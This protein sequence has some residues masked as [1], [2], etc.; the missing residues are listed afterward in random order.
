MGIH[1]MEAVIKKKG[2]LA[3][4]AERD[5]LSELQKATTSLNR[6][7]SIFLRLPQFL[8]YISLVPKLCII[9]FISHSS[10]LVGIEQESS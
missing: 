8:G 3:I 6:E 7:Y 2:E 1:G 5:A 9:I 10:K 4:E